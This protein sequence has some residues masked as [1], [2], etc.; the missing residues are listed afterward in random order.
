MK[1]TSRFGLIAASA[2]VVVVLAA[3]S[4]GLK[5]GSSTENRMNRMKRIA[6][7]EQS[8]SRLVDI[9]RFERPFTAEEK[10]KYVVWMRSVGSIKDDHEETVV[11]EM[12]KRSEAWE[13]IPHGTHYINGKPF[14]NYRE[15][16]AA[17]WSIG[18]IA[19]VN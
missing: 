5:E 6:I 10:E 19:C 8:K 1:I 11:R 18:S 4:W 12:F 7:C 15:K 16:E 9:V 13:N 14:Q 3:A 2:S 17:A